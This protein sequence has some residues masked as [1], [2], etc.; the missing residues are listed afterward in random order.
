[1]VEDRV[2]DHS[3]FCT[4]KFLNLS[5]RRIANSWL[6]ATLRNCL[7]LDATTSL[8]RIRD[9]TE[10]LIAWHRGQGATLC[11]NLKTPHFRRIP[12]N[13]NAYATTSQGRRAGA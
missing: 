3:T 10:H 11:D 7:S 5:L 4:A 6:F 8:T 12:A 2:P 9:A 13:A 1:M